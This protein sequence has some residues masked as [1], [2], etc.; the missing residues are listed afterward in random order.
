MNIL[1]NLGK[2]I[3]LLMLMIALVACSPAE[4]IGETPI[5]KEKGTEVEES[6][7]EQQA[8]PTETPQPTATHIEIDGEANDWMD[9]RLLYED[10]AGDAEDEYLDFGPLVGGH[11]GCDQFLQ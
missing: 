5:V 2:I 1:S 3:T 4:P 9:R 8:K 6:S 10:A 7:S 11:S